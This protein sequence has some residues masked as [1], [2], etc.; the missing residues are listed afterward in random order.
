MIQDDVGP[1]VVDFLFGSTG[2]DA[3]WGT[4]QP[5][6]FTW[7]AHRLAQ[8]VWADPPRVVDGTVVV[9]AHA[10]T[11]LVRDVPLSDN[12]SAVVGVLNR[13]A[14]LSAYVLDP[15]TRRATMHCAMT[16][17]RENVGWAQRLLLGAIGLQVAEAHGRADAAGLL[18]GALDSSAHPE[19]GPRPDPDEML[20]VLRRLFVPVGAGESRFAG[21]EFVRTAGLCQNLGLLAYGDAGGLTAEFPY[22]GSRPV[23]QLAL[24]GSAGGLETALLTAT[25]ETRH[26]Q[27]GSGALLRL[28]LPPTFERAK[29][30]EL[31]RRLNLAEA[32]MYVDQH[33][34]GAWCP[35]DRRGLAFVAF[36][37]SALH[38]PG[39]LDGLVLGEG[40]RA[41]WAREILDQGKT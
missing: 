8:R 21:D 39:L 15:H 36:I 19:S 18:G 6:G 10:E 29:A 4:R 2:I 32:R 26:P 41:R 24:E 20:S 22:T 17:H 5:R 30:E 28:H 13:V 3:Q 1:E 40:L 12:L 7:W 14:S 35:D 16:L 25:A 31:A 38:R 34:L 11:D 27:L 37:P 23:M 9:R 33:T